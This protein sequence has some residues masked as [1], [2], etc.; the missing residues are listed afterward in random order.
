VKN[1]ARDERAAHFTISACKVAILSVLF[2]EC[3]RE[4]D[5]QAAVPGHLCRA[6]TKH[7]V[8]VLW[9]LILLETRPDF[10]LVVQH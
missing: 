10:L 3:L 1:A 2:G 7:F 9:E 8:P 4:E 5:C 6:Y